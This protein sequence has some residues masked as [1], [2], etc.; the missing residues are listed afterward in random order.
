MC[1]V[2]YGGNECVFGEFGELQ[3]CGCLI[4]FGY[5]KCFDVNVDIFDGDWLCIGDLFIKDEDGF[6]W[7]VGCFKEMIK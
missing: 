6:Y 2:D 7:I 4:M 1:V 3:I 5:Y